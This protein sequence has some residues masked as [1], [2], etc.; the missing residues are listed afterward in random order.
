MI[1]YPISRLILS[2]GALLMNS[3]VYTL[4]LVNQICSTGRSCPLDR[5]CIIDALFVLISLH[6]SKH[7]FPFSF[8]ILSLS[9]LF[10]S[11]H[12]F[13]TPLNYFNFLMLKYDCP[14]TLAYFHFP[15]SFLFFYLFSPPLLLLPP[16]LSL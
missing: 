9:L 2:S 7:S 11:L 3:C 1:S 15:H 6:F 12:H 10:Y 14:S 13:S 8:P 16:V 4:L 5:N